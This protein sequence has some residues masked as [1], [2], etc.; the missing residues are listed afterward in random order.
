MAGESRSYSAER[1]CGYK[2]LTVAGI[3]TRPAQSLFTPPENPKVFGSK[4]VSFR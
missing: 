4:S 1:R 2:H 3:I